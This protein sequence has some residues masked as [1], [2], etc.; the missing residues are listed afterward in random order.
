MNTRWIL[1]ALLAIVAAGLKSQMKSQTAAPDR[2]PQFTADNQLILPKEYR[3]WVFLSSG[4]G[5]TYGTPE[6][7]RQGNFDNVFVYPAAYRQFVQTGHWPEGTIFIVEQRAASSKG[8]VNKGSVGRYQSDLLGI[9]A[10]VKDRSRAPEGEWVYFS[11][12]T[13]AQTAPA[14]PKTAACYSCH[15]QNAAVENTFVQF[16]PTLLPIARAKGVLK[17]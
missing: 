6:A 16:Y 13:D 1:L 2:A 3:E 8:V 12:R 15:S 5:M 11:F 4:I 7:E 17:P 9:G 10:E 14:L